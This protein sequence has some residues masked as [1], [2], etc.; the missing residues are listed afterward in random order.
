MVKAIL[1]DNQIICDEC[2]ARLTY[3]EDDIE[4]GQ[5]GLEQIKC[6]VCGEILM[7]GDEERKILPNYPK[8]FHHFDGKIGHDLTDTEIN[9]HLISVM[10]TI[11]HEPNREYA[12]CSS[13]D[14]AVI[15]MNMG[16][17]MV[18]VVGKKYYEDAIE[19]EDWERLSKYL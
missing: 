8:T 6:P 13:D 1:E 16:S 17:E 9:Q 3:D 7:V 5:F 11:K 4:I 15:G 12:Y 19:M 18:F 14:T 2:R 10:K